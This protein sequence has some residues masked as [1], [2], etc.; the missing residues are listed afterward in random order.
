MNFY[1]NQTYHLLSSFALAEI[2]IDRN[3]SSFR[4]PVRLVLRCLAHCFSCEKTS[5]L[6]VILDHKFGKIGSFKL[7]PRFILQWTAREL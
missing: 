1:F 6:R 3:P 7:T 2:L 4:Q 5:H